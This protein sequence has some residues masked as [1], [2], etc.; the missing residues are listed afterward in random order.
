MGSVVRCAADQDVARVQSLS[1]SNSGGL[2]DPVAKVC[3]RTT[4]T[5]EQILDE[6]ICGKDLCNR[7]SRAV[8][9]NLAA[10]MLVLSSTVYILL[11]T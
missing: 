8:G 6:C 11:S 4:H 10:L 3:V 9:I 2:I 1:N 5:S 7:S